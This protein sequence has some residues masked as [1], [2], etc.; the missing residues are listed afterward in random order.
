L[1]AV[2]GLRWCVLAGRTLPRD[3]LH[4]DRAGRAEQ[5]P[6]LL[7]VVSAVTTVVVLVGSRR[8]LAKAV[9]TQGRR[10]PLHRPH[11]TSPA[12]TGEDGCGGQRALGRPVATG[13]GRAQGAD[14]RSGRAGGTVRVTPGGAPDWPSGG[15]WMRG[16]VA[17][18]PAP[19]GTRSLR[20]HPLTPDARPRPGE[21]PVRTALSPRYLIRM[22]SEVQVLPGPPFGL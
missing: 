20:T 12:A 19:L 10:P 7:A 5:D 21:T 1:D 11:R 4:D 2:K 17:C 18:L 16:S 9:R 3:R 14:P 6:P 15:P 22:K 13:P 8:A